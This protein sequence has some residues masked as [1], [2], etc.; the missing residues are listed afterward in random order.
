MELISISTENGGTEGLGPLPSPGEGFGQPFSLARDGRALYV[1]STKLGLRRWEIGAPQ[2]TTVYEGANVIGLSP[3]ERWIVRRE[4]G[5]VVEI[6]P[7]SGGDW[8]PLISL[9][10]NQFA[11]TQDG[12]WLIYH[13]TD[14]SGKDGLFRVATAGGDPERLGDFPAA[15]TQGEIWISPDGRKLITDT[16]NPRE[17]WMLENFEPKP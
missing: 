15:S 17:L 4:Q 14:G 9:R 11:F 1:A 13:D 6:R 3:D 5:R 2:L 16:L 12:N 7:M 10:E 8:K